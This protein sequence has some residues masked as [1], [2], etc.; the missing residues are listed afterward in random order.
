MFGYKGERLLDA[1][2]PSNTANSYVSVFYSFL[3]T[4]HSQ[5]PA[6]TLD[7]PEQ[8]PNSGIDIANNTKEVK[9]PV[10]AETKVPVHVADAVGQESKRLI[11]PTVEE[12]TLQAGYGNELNVSNTGPSVSSSAFANEIEQTKQVVAQETVATKTL[13]GSVQQSPALP[14]V[15]TVDEQNDEGN[16]GGKTGSKDVTNTVQERNKEL[17][18][19]IDPDF[20][21]HD[22]SVRGVSESGSFEQI[23][24]SEID[25]PSNAK[26]V[27]QQV[28]AGETEMPVANAVGQESPQLLT[29]VSE[30]APAKE[31]KTL[32]EATSKAGNGSEL[33]VFDAGPTVSS[34]A[35]HTLKR[36][37]IVANEIEEVK[38]VVVQGTA[39]TKTLTESV[40]KSST[41]Q[42]KTIVDDQRFGE[43]NKDNE[44][45]SRDVDNIVQKTNK[46]LL[47]SK[48]HDREESGVDVASNVKEV[49]QQV[50][51]VGETEIAFAGTVVQRSQHLT[52]VSEKTSINETKIVEQAMLQAGLQSEIKVFDAGHTVLDS[53]RK[54]SNNVIIVAREI[55]ATE[56]VVLEETV[57]TETLRESVQQSPASPGGKA[58]DEQNSIG[59][60]TNPEHV[61][62][63]GSTISDLPSEE[64]VNVEITVQVPNKE[65][66]LPSSENSPNYSRLNGSDSG[67]NSNEPSG[68][69]K[70]DDGRAGKLTNNLNPCTK[71]VE[72][73][74][75]KSEM[76]SLQ[77]L[78]EVFDKFN[79]FVAEMPTAGPRNVSNET[80]TQELVQQSAVKDVGEK[81]V[82]EKDEGEKKKGE[83]KKGEK[84]EG[85][86]DESEKDEGEMDEGE[87][88]E[89]EKDEC[90]V[91][92]G[93]EDEGEEDEGEE[94]EGEEDEG[95]E[96]EGEEDEGEED[97]GEEDEGEEDEGEKDEGK[98]DESK[99]DEGVKME[100]KK[101][102]GEPSEKEKKQ[103]EPREGENKDGKNKKDKKKETKK[104]KNKTKKGE[105]KGSEKIK[106][107]K[108]KDEKK[109][110]KSQ[111]KHEK[112]GKKLEI[113]PDNGSCNGKGTTASSAGGK[114]QTAKHKSG[115]VQVCFRLETT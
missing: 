22:E 90:E 71:V 15:A 115:G 64:N 9:Q 97:E 103:G 19:N 110:E 106:S 42:E 96:D 108:E 49:K 58:V 8:I 16:E 105:K 101:S 100:S 76:P 57:V 40:E 25:V 81:D 82:G 94:D 32:E 31:T 93:E 14:E 104:K 84:D 98:K 113:N 10:V 88:D 30:K 5:T 37:T 4:N 6:S 86:K 53:A 89:G 43:S 95:E 39:V 92:E 48:R 77:G 91:D 102:K 20:P 28:L 18:P 1:C 85:D 51:V 11:I 112:S 111:K 3:D 29:A 35:E 7:S 13:T 109:D 72:K 2:I 80:P 99:K 107:E 34:D 70:D 46:D 33:N 74:V 63:L 79:K 23:S 68:I 66:L 27:K 87:K 44:T 65:L 55:E 83:K 67:T 36:V 45:S 62:A 73:P 54:T 61:L 26:E 12:A 75:L 21:C 78:N 17:M 52:A 41:S 24:S 60:K 38:Q 56:Q 114:D 50:T 69:I 59:S 47:S